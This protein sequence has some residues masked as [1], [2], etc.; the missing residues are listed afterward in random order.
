MV[1]IN[2]NHRYHTLKPDEDKYIQL[3]EIL[4][5]FAEKELYEFILNEITY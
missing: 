1:K 3:R 5:E 4:K 2:N